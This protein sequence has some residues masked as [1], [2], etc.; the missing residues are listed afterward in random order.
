LD[1]HKGCEERSISALGNQ[2]ELSPSPETKGAGDDEESSPVKEKEKTKDQPVVFKFH[3]LVIQKYIEKPLLINNRK[4][5]FRVWVLVTHEMNC[6]FFKEGYIRMSS[7]VYDLSSQNVENKFIHL[8]NN[9]VQ[10]YSENYCKFE[11]GNQLSF[12]DFEKY[13]QSN[14]LPC[15]F[16]GKMLPKLKQAALFSMESVKRKLNLEDRKYVFEIFGYDYIIDADFNAWLIE[17]NTN[18][19]IEESSGILEMLLPRM[20]DDAF[21]LTLDVIFPAPQITQVSEENAPEF[22]TSATS[23]SPFEVDNYGNDVNMW[24]Y[25]GCLKTTKAVAPKRR[26]RPY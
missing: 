11:S 10:K 23:R 18:P 7:E 20:I 17:V 13:I 1:Y 24:E 6:Y 12:D 3:T 15:D 16:R 9:A 26:S 4:F 2:Q 19:C 22:A 14:G 8:T 5:D 25:Q 21:R